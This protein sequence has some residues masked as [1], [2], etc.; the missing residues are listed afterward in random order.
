LGD[1]WY[2]ANLA[3]KSEFPERIREMIPNYDKKLGLYEV[4]FF[5]RGF[6][7]KFFV[8]DRLPSIYGQPR[9]A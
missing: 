9:F 5:D 3:A 1:C 2:I 6:P 7:V 4:R 8:D